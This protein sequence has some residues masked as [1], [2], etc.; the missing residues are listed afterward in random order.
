MAG[1]WAAH[2]L[3]KD[4]GKIF[5]GVVTKV[6]ATIALALLAVLGGMF[7]YMLNL[8]YQKVTHS[9]GRQVYG[10]EHPIKITQIDLADLHT[11]NQLKDVKIKTSLLKITE[12]FGA[13]DI[14]HPLPSPY[15]KNKE[16]L[17]L[18]INTYTEWIYVKDKYLLQ[19][20]SKDQQVVAYSITQRTADF[21]PVIP[22][23]YKPSDERA[24][25][26]SDGYEF[27]S[28]RLGELSFKKLRDEHPNAREN[29][30]LGGSSK[31]EFYVETYYFGFPGYYNS[32]LFASTTT[33]FS[34][35][36]KAFPNIADYLNGTLFKDD[37]KFKKYYEWWGEALP[38]SFIIVGQGH[39][40]L[41]H[42]LIQNPGPVF[43]DVMEKIDRT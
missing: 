3:K 14:S 10:M 27:I 40:D 9:T 5:T 19:L 13:P 43:Y 29:I 26:G 1:Y 2:S 33:Y 7:V 4:A 37:E 16:S 21:Q 25:V 42:Y 18:E 11:Y 31:E 36:Q 23:V 6:I 32:F 8:G 17:P 22:Y 39:D 15:A 30:H 12:S 24:S 20:I 35:T 28:Y 41:V 34:A 38:N